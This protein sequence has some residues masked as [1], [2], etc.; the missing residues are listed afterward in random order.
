MSVTETSETYRQCPGCAHERLTD[1]TGSMVEHRVFN[2]T[3]GQMVCAAPV[4]GARGTSSI[5]RKT[6]RLHLPPAG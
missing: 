4:Q 3:L 5:P 2:P 1:D 6:D